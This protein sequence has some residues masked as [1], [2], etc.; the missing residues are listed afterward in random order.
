MPIQMLRVLLFVIGD[1]HYKMNGRDLASS[2]KIPRRTFI[3]NRRGSD[4]SINEQTKK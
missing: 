4:C 1:F 3:N 2:D